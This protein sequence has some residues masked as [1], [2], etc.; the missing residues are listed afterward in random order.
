MDLRIQKTLREIRMAF[1]SLAKEK[2]LERITVKELCDRALI[3]K[4]TFYSH[5]DN[6]DSLIEQMEDEFVQKLT[7]DIE[8]AD[9]F[10]RNPEQFISTLLHRFWEMPEGVIL[11]SSPRYLQIIS[12]LL[13][14]LRRSIYKA[15]PEI[16]SIP[17]I[18][19]ALTYIVM[20]FT[21]VITMHNKESIELRAREAGRATTAV[22]REVLGHFY[23][24]GTI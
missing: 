16:K 23:A 5:Y 4:A 20:G 21:G 2:P 1:L 12:M 7:G 17:G 8:Y 19:M 10:F 13:E 15:R 9:L 11:L 3:N 24:P 14:S 22:L 18:D 6:L